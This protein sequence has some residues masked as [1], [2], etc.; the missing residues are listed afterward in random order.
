MNTKSSAG[1]TH[2]GEATFPRV[3][4]CVLD[5]YQEIRV[6]VSEGANLGAALRQA[7]VPYTFGGGV[8]RICAGTA[9]GLR[10]HLVVHTGGPERPYEYG[11][12][13]DVD[14]E[15]AFVSGAITVGR[16]DANLPIVHCHAGFTDERGVVHGGHVVLENTRVGSEPVV[17]RMCLFTAGGFATRHDAETH[18]KLLHPITVARDE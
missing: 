2:K 1:F 8:G 13:L 17:V 7:L 4:D 15:I 3:I 16:N 10:Y 14:K 12:P 5:D 11:E 6:T 18:F 9:R